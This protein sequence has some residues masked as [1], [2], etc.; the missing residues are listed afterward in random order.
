MSYSLG[1]IFNFRF[2]DNKPEIYCR[3]S[4]HKTKQNIENTT[5][6]KNKYNLIYTITFTSYIGLY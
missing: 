6:D 3:L 1:I 4:H 2:I 5:L